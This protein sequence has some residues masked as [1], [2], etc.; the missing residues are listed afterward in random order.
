MDEKE[1]AMVADWLLGYAIS[2]EYQDNMIRYNSDS[3]SLLLG[4][5]GEIIPDTTNYDSPEF[6]KQVEE[7][8]KVLRIP[9]HPDHR[10]VLKAALEIVEKKFSEEA[11][12]RERNQKEQKK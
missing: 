1:Y 6:Q 3:K 5:K 9:I 7:L 2:L 10:V 12:K 11:L 8:A 4:G